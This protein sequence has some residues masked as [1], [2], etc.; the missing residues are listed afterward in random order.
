MTTAKLSGAVIRA[1]IVFAHGLGDGRRLKARSY[2][3]NSWPVGFF[4][5]KRNAACYILRALITKSNRK[6]VG[7]YI[8]YLIQEDAK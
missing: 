5:G 6:A 8:K 7:E 4:T 2:D 3:E 1:C